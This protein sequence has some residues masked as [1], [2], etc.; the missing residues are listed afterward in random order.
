MNAFNSMNARGAGIALAAVLAL[1]GCAAEPET[2]VVTITPSVI[3]VSPPA[4]T[5]PT[6]RTR[7]GV[8]PMPG[9]RE[10]RLQSFAGDV[11]VADDRGGGFVSHCVCA[12]NECTCQGASGSCQP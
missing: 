1:A 5:A 12:G 2:K 10:I 11:C 8:A 3:A 6:F 4:A 9:D 7:I